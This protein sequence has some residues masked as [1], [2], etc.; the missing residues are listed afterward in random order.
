MQGIDG[1]DWRFNCRLHL[2]ESKAR[3]LHG[4]QQVSLP[5]VVNFAD[6]VILAGYPP[7][8]DKREASGALDAGS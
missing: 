1:K 8:F 4:Q 2:Q 7:I 3:M 6:M 5:Q